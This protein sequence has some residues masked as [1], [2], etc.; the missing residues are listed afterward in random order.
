MQPL[1]LVITQCPAC[2]KDLEQNVATDHIASLINKHSVIVL[3]GVT[4]ISFLLGEKGLGSF[5][6]NKIPQN[7]PSALHTQQQQQ[8]QRQ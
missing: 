1:T 7:L 6:Q 2:R 4:I 5:M 3:L 8:Q